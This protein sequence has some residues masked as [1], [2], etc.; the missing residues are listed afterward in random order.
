MNKYL[1]TVAALAVMSV[2]ATAW[3]Y[4]AADAYTT[5]EGACASYDARCK[6]I[7]YGE[8]ATGYEVVIWSNGRVTVERY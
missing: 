3:L 2:G 7:Q 6:V 4:S 5:G 8:D 1:L